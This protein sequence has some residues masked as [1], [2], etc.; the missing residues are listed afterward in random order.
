M[1]WIVWNENN[2]INNF[3]WHCPF[4]IWDFKNLCSATQ[5]FSSKIQ[6]WYFK[7]PFKNVLFY[8]SNFIP[9]KTP[10]CNFSAMN[11]KKWEK[12]DPESLSISIP[13]VNGSIL[14]VQNEESHST[15]ALM[16]IS[17]IGVCIWLYTWLF[18]F[19]GWEAGGVEG[20]REDFQI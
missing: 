5:F 6:T 11:K 14:S 13:W 9:L 18:Y 16:L 15:F 3:F 2:Q 17:C 20:F 7:I 12:N 10:V 1:Y 4:I 8:I 19:R